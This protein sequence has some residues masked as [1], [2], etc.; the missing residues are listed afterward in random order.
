MPLKDTRLF[1]SIS[2]LDVNALLQQ[3]ITHFFAGTNTHLCNTA[4]V[5]LLLPYLL[6]QYTRRN[7][8]HVVTCRC[9]V[10]VHSLLTTYMRTFR[11]LNCHTSYNLL[12]LC[13]DWCGLLPWCCQEIQ[14]QWLIYESSA[15]NSDSIQGWQRI[16]HMT[17]CR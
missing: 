9:L 6:H 13:T 2:T 3:P 4:T 8:R 14:Y 15:T 12:Q 5:S 10:T 17:C 11:E 16:N 1:H 7:H